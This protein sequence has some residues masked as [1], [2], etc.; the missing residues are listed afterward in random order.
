MNSGRPLGADTGQ[1]WL[2]VARVARLLR[3]P[4]S[5]VV[6]LARGARIYA[7][8]DEWG[9]WWLR[10][11]SVDRYLERHGKGPAQKPHGVAR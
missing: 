4:W 11:D 9:R 6:A 10:S 7:K 5:D 1:V 8:L 3:L 2:P